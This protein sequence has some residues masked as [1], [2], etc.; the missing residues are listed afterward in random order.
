MG[1]TGVLTAA[2]LPRGCRVVGVTTKP[3]LVSGQELGQRLSDQDNW[4]RDY[5]LPLAKFRRLGRVE[6]IHDRVTVVDPDHRTATVATAA[7][8]RG[9]LPGIT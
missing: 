4:R 6:I 9:I 2:H 8:T 1:D 5:L 7:G 3:M